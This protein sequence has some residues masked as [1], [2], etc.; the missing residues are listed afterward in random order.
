VAVATLCQCALVSNACFLGKP[1]ST[2]QTASRSVQLFLHSSRSTVPICYNGRPFCAQNC[3]FSR[4]IWSPI[5]HVVSWIQPTQ[6]RKRHLVRFGRFCTAHCRK[7]VYF[8]MGAPFPQNCPFPWGSGALS[9]TWFLRPT[10]IL[11]PNG[12]SI[13]SAVLQD[14]LL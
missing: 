13:D 8:R 3:H 14:S 11:N 7:S 6:Y 10:R 2:T 12:M 5:L 4:G 1:E 9:D